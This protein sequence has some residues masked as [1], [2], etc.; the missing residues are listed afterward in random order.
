MTLSEICDRLDASVSLL[1]RGP[2]TAS[3]R[4][5]TLAATLD[6]SYQLLSPTEQA[7]LRRLSVFAGTF[8]L[9]A[10]RPVASLAL[11]A[12]EDVRPQVW[13]LCTK[14]LVVAPNPAQSSRF[15]LL[16][17]TRQFAH[18]HLVASGERPVAE[19][20]F[21]EYYVD[22]ASRAE[23]DL[24]GPNQAAVFSHLRGDHE[25]LRRAVN[26]LA[27]ST[28]GIEAALRMLTQLQRYWLFSGDQAEWLELAVPLTAAVN[29]PVRPE[30]KARA[31]AAQCFLAS[32]FDPAHA[33]QCGDESLRLARRGGDARSECEALT[34]L[35]VNGLFSDR[36][37]PSTAERA[38]LVARQTGEAA[39]IGQA[40]AALSFTQVQD[41]NT[42]VRRNLEAIEFLHANGDHLFEVFSL[43]NLGVIYEQADDLTQATVYTEQA[44]VLASQ[45]G[46][47]FPIGLAN[48]AELRIRQ[49]QLEAALEP[50]ETGLRLARRRSLRDLLITLRVIVR[51]AATIGD[52][53]KAAQLQGYFKTV[54]MS[55]GFEASMLNDR[56]AQENEALVNDAPEELVE[57]HSRAGASMNSQSAIELAEQI[58]QLS[59]SPP[60]YRD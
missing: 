25:N 32:S 4:Q 33:R 52:Y 16:E 1:T 41:M 49:G 7:T 11:R 38:L 14:S 36:L 19:A 34:A 28:D 56:F 24:H 3:P 29:T 20:V 54:W 37:A 12:V 30:V 43:N 39:L 57:M 9:D 26:L 55:A 42:A 22:V 40:L 21:S 2:R 13:A 8:D 45:I 27:A 35:A 23:F 31:L 58:V 60:Q 47:G 51:L 5:Q 17:P 59:S 48:L 46:Y 44:T 6:W 53:A 10:A 50:L 18:Q 15:R